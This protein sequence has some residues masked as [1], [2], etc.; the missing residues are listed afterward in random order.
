MTA[1]A[2]TEH[3]TYTLPNLKKLPAVCIRCSSAWPCFWNLYASTSASYEAKCNKYLLHVCEVIKRRAVEHSETQQAPAILSIQNWWQIYYYYRALCHDSK[4]LTPQCICLLSNLNLPFS[5]LKWSGD[6]KA[7]RSGQ[8]A[9][10]IE[11]TW[12]FWHVNCT[13]KKPF[14]YQ[15]WQ[16]TFYKHG[17]YGDGRS[18]NTH[19]NYVDHSV[20]CICRDM[21]K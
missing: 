2:A 11:A 18:I 17:K 5:T 9:R 13:S 8:E 6:Y 1:A 16:E 3:P 12:G 14:N 7:Q 10:L 20:K 21:E 15:P 19:L 4:M